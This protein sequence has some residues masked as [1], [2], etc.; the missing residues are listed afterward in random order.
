MNIYFLLGFY[1][2]D[3]NLGVNDDAVR[4]YCNMTAGGETCVYPGKQITINLSIQLS[5]HRIIHI[6]NLLI[7]NLSV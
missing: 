1:W 2:I 6:F 5:I 4:V 7:S 3:P